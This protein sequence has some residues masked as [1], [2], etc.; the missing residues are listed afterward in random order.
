MVYVQ[1]LGQGVLFINSYNVAVDLLEKK[2]T[3]YAD[4]PHMVMA[5]ELYV[6]RSFTALV[7]PNIFPQVR[8]R[9]YRAWTRAVRYMTRPQRALRSRSRGLATVFADTAR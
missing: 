9:E 3:L 5:A 6:F 1:V 7:G 8:L 4:R 2:G